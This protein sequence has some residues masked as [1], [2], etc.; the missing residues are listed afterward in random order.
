MIHARYIRQL[1]RD[2]CQQ[3][4]L[5]SLN[6]FSAQ[7]VVNI[8]NGLNH[9][10]ESLKLKSYLYFLVGHI[11]MYPSEETNQ[12]NKVKIVIQTEIKS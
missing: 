8:G 1:P 9:I 5:R 10:A 12:I 3:L 6:K 2:I 11:V 4:Y 7:S